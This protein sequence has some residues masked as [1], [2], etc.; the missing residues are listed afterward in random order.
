MLAEVH[1]ILI[2]HSPNTPFVHIWFIY[3]LDIFYSPRLAIRW[4]SKKEDFSPMIY[5]NLYESIV[6]IYIHIPYPQYV[7]IFSHYVPCMSHF[8]SHG[9]SRHVPVSISGIARPNVGWCFAGTGGHFCHKAGISGMKRCDSSCLNVFKS[10]GM[11]V[12]QCE[13]Y[14]KSIWMVC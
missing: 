1:P 13:C 14:F 10:H 4:N 3:V 9:V 12:I 7:H 11:S 8:L 6:P 2:H 5:M